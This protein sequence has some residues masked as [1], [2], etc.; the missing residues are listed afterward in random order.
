MSED[1]SPKFI[2]LK[3]FPSVR[4]KVELSLRAPAGRRAWR[5]LEELGD[6]PEFRAMMD[7]EFPQA[8]SEWDDNVSRR[9][10]IKLMGASIALA[11]LTTACAPK[12]EEKI[13][14]YVQQPEILVPGKPLFYA[15][16]MPWGGF[17]KGVLVEQ[18]EGR[19]TKIEGNPDHPASMG[20]S[21]V[22][23]QASIL[24]LYDPDRSQAITKFGNVNSW[25]TFLNA[26]DSVLNFEDWNGA[27]V[28][29]RASAGARIH[30]LTETTTSPTFKA[31]VEA[32]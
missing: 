4:K 12:P 25:G 14:P 22:W 1:R 28:K 23:G 24:T 18:H 13:I 20:A 9:N 10:F 17:G 7:R 8:A 2:D 29:R 26:F 15:S 30:L 16:A 21:D 11:G 31:Q 6:T 27:K 32:L 3:D 19:P 5:S